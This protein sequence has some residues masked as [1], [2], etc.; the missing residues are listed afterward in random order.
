[1]RENVPKWIRLT[2]VIEV[3]EVDEEKKND[4]FKII[5]VKWKQNK[6]VELNTACVFFPYC[7][8]W[9]FFRLI[10]LEN[11]QNCLIVYFCDEEI[12]FGLLSL[13]VS[14]LHFDFFD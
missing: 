9:I 11:E 3:K 4:N 10:E 13:I 5:L 6:N 7:C 14:F 12:V 8:Q 2:I 1:M